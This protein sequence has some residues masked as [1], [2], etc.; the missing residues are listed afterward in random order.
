MG[1]FPPK[2]TLWRWSPELSPGWGFSHAQIPEQ[3]PKIPPIFGPREGI[4][5]LSWCPSQAWKNL[6]KI[7]GAAANP[8]RRVW[9]SA[10][11]QGNSIRI[12]S[13]SRGDTAPR[14][15]FVLLKPRNFEKSQKS[16]FFPPFFSP[17]PSGFFSFSW[18]VLQ[19][20]KE[21]TPAKRFRE[22]TRKKKT[23]KE[24][25]EM[26]QKTSC[27]GVKKITILFLPGLFFSGGALCTFRAA[28]LHLNQC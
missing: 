27:C 19:L 22:L 12:W 26:L 4:L 24:K 5:G 7:T 8:P 15:S 18:S 10:A 16:D 21:Q 13:R 1:F 17:P 3:I 2:N 9:V 20:F 28:I 14:P 23:W 25:P 6:G 11:F